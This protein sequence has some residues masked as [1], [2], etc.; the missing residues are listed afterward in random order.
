MAST[1]TPQPLS[2]DLIVEQAFA[3]IDEA[4]L[5]AF[6]L[7]ALGRR[8][9]ASPMALYTYFP[10]KDALVDAVFA[11]MRDEYDNAPVP[12]ERW[13]DTLRRTTASIRAVDLAH[14]NVY[15][16][17]SGWMPEAR[18]NTRRVYQIFRDQGMPVE[19]FKIMWSTLEAFLV[20]FIHQEVAQNEAI[21]A[22]R[23]G[24]PAG[25]DDAGQPDADAVDPARPWLAIARSAYG[26]ESFS[27]GIELVIEGIRQM[28]GPEEQTWR[29]PLDPREW[30][31]E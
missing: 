14:P 12:G 24:A 31:W 15:K 30:T 4:G 21:A 5:E 17:L 19:T 1:R 3:L 27:F 10:S 9:Q 16:A 29:T 26:D 22:D 13:D 18:Q 7:R 28:A 25:G 11:R 8:L 6:S 23:G 2:R 20:G